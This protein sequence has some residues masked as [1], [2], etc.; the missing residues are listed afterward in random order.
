MSEKANRMTYG[1]VATTPERSDRPVDQDE[2]PKSAATR[3]FDIRLL[4]GGLFTLYGIMLGVAGLFTSHAAREKAAGININLW[5][6][7]GMLILGILFLVWQRLN[8]LRREV[9]EGRAD[10]DD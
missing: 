10:Q 6:G 9:A 7:I 5:L 4:I 2:G 8:P 1:P 3:L